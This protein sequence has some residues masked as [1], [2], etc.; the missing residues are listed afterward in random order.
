[1]LEEFK[2]HIH[3]QF[4]ELIQHKFLLAC[5]GGLDSV[6]LAQLC[7]QCKLEF[8]LA[9]CNFKLRAAESNK[10]EQFV[11]ELAKKLNK[12]FFVKEFATSKYARN[13]KVSVQMAA[14]NLRYEWFN[15]LMEEQHIKTLV[16]AHHA[17]DNLETF[18]I[19]LSRGT[20]IKGLTGIPSRTNNIMRPL[21]PFSRKRILEFAQNEKIAWR[22]DQSNAEIKYLRNKIRHEIVPVLKELHPTFL[23][24]FAVTQEYLKQIATIS[25]S[26]I[27][28]LKEE[29][30]KVDGE[31]IRIKIESIQALAPLEAYIHALF[32]EY[33][34]TEWEDLQN[35]LTA[36]SG[37]AVHSRTHRLVKDRDL[38]LLSRIT[39]K[40][41]TQYNISESCAQIENPISLSIRYVD[42][43]EETGP[44]VLYVDKETLK[45][46]LTLRKWQKGDY[47]YPL[48]MKG[49][50]KI[51]KYY[52]DEK[53]DV[54]AKEKQWLL[55][56]G[57]D[58]IWVVG[59]RADDRF[60]V[61][62]ST[63]NILK[64]ILN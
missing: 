47:F 11:R 1:M 7:S 15:Q 18:I 27:R 36:M 28:Q 57:D 34:F 41:E 21:L 22:E 43:I 4:P 44:N 23:D 3:D 40:V 14:R 60:K 58:V 33:G 42:L 56:A 46:P 24:N 16:T 61:T 17:D 9:H 64:I 51:S 12:S 29:L 20:G 48:G 37:K 53:V 38:L 52:K 63:K 35:L 45:Y 59:K 8:S 32:S 25:D 5:S 31:V 55:C 13:Q 10:D 26:H 30:F 50:K 62:N 54:L 2:K 39:N 49:R 19:N 6:V